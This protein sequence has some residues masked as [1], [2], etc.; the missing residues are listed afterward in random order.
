MICLSILKQP[1]VYYTVLKYRH[2]GH[3]T[4]PIGC[5]SDI[6]DAMQAIIVA[7][8]RD[9]GAYGIQSSTEKPRHWLSKTKYK[10]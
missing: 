2:G 4:Y 7:Y 5:Y 6:R 1:N 9:E 10:D 8:R 3:H